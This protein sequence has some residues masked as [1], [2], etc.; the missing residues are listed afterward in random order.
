MISKK[1]LHCG[2][3]F[4]IPNCRE[5]TARFCSISCATTYRNLKDN[6]SKRDDVRKKIS[7]NHADVSGE[8]NP[9]Y[10][11]KGELAPSYKDGRSYFKGE[12]HSKILQALGVKKECR[13]CGSTDK[14]Q[15]HHI[16]GNHKNNE[17]INLVYLCC[18]CHQTIAHEIIRNNGRFASRKLNNVEGYNGKNLN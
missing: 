17:I 2:K 12:T 14:I 16:D 8:N 3:D 9:M 5:K 13:I 1:C 7:L 10:G 6:P 15:V 18:K 4:E 11:R